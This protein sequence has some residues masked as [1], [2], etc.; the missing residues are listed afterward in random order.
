[1]TAVRSGA[2]QEAF[3]IVAL[4]ART[5][6]DKESRTIWLE[7]LKVTSASFPGALTSRVTWKGLFVTRF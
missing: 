7:D 1:V 4:S 6:V 3:G 5:D 2:T